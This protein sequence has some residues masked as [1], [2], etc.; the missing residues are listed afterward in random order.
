MEED[1]KPSSVEQTTSEEPIAP[2]IKPEEEKA[3]ILQGEEPVKAENMLVGERRKRIIELIRTTGLSPSDIAEN[4]G[5]KTSTVNNDIFR[6][7]NKGKLTSEEISNWQK[8]RQLQHKEESV[9]AR[10]ERIIDLIRTTGLNQKEIAQRVDVKHAIVFNDV[11]YFRLHRL[12]TEKEIEERKER[13]KQQHTNQKLRERRERVIDLIRT[14]GLGPNGISTEL[15][16]NVSIISDDIQYLRKHK[17]LTD[18]EISDWK[19]RRKQFS[20]VEREK[21]K[22]AKAEKVSQEAEEQPLQETQNMESVELMEAKEV[23]A[24]QQSE[25]KEDVVEQPQ[26]PGV[27]EEKPKEPGEPAQSSEPVE[28]EQPEIQDTVGLKEKPEKIARGRAEKQYIVMM[29]GKIKVLSLKGETEQAIRYLETLQNEMTFTEAEQK[30]FD[31]IMKVLQKA[32]I[33]E[34]NRRYFNT[35]N[36]TI[37]QNEGR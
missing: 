7:K 16:T 23:T 10:R 33:K 31:G 29:I 12:I 13:I 18:K 11:R 6:L 3:P 14:T 21:K 26:G 27:V 25:P 1:S 35:G 30:Q 17:K 28:V 19:E 37:G 15:E 5:I 2:T 22:V 9:E 32:R 36:T 20:E 8:R 4:L 24:E 34:I